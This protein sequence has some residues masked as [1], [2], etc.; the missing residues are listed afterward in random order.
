MAQFEP[1]HTLA[2]GGIRDGAGR[3]PKAIVEAITDEL[4][5]YQIKFGDKKVPMGLAA[6]RVMAEG[7]SGA[8]ADPQVMAVRLKA[9]DLVLN[10]LIG[11]PKQSMDLNLSGSA[12]LMAL[13]AQAGGPAPQHVA[14]INAFADPNDVGTDVSKPAVDVPH[15]GHRDRQGTKRKPAAKGD[16]PRPRRKG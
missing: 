11:K 13:I 16:G 2:P 1:G 3:K 15:N 7:M 14:E 4:T 6:V 9:A 8:F 12:A 10:R 5:T